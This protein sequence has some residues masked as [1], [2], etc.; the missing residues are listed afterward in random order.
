MSNLWD[1]ANEAFATPI[2]ALDI[3]IERLDGELHIAADDWTLVLE[4]D[5]ISGAL[6]AVD[7]EQDTP[8]NII[9]DV[10]ADGHLEAMR[11]LD[12]ATDGKLRAALENSPDPLA[13]ALSKRIG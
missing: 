2:E 10:V 4:G 13:N 11:A 12:K 7:D 9:S 5:P 3:A 8:D 1:A 6:F